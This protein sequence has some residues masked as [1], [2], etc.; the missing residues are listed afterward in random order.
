MSLEITVLAV[1]K[2]RKKFNKLYRS[3]PKESLTQQTQVLLKDF[4]RYFAEHEDVTSIEHD[5]FMPW[6][7]LVAH[8]KLAPETLQ[9]FEQQLKQV[10]KPLHPSVEAGLMN[11]LIANDKATQLYDLI[12]R[13]NEGEEVDLL[14]GTKKLVQE[15]EQDVKKKVKST[16]V[17]TSIEEMMLEDENDFGF[18]WRL[19][20]L[21]LSMRPMRGGDFGI[22]AGRPDKGKTSFM[23]CEL[24]FMAQQLDKLWPGQNRSILWMNNEGPGKRIKYRCYQ[25]ALD[26]TSS[27][28]LLK[29]NAGTLQSEYEAAV[30]RAN[31]IRVF[32][33]HGLWN[34]EVQEIVEANN[35]GLVVFDMIDNIRFAG[36]ATNNGQRTDQLLEAM[37]QWGRM[38]AV[39]WDVPVLATSQISADGDGLAYPTLPMLKDSKTGKQ[40]A[41]EFIITLG[42]LN[43]Q[44]AQASRYIGMTKNKLHR[45][46]GPRDPRCEV[47]FD[48]LR[49][50]YRMPT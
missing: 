6:F 7:K 49:G 46:G 2:D 14:A 34:H 19:D 33:I 3:I 38:M 1:V 4:E 5:A 25:S 44:T 31:A 17:T 21:N 24:S 43:E 22:I 23:T 18:H 37:Y 45:E 48:G 20:C 12:Q 36:E 28:L 13:F 47:I 27:E 30:G 39:V 10:H 11:R 40:G 16:E 15:F 32:D 9:V 35:P 50:R 26:A 29:Q 42:A 8:P 41:A